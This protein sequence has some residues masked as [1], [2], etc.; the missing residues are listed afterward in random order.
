MYVH[1]LNKVEG[2]LADTVVY[3]TVT[4][5]GMSLADSDF[6]RV[7]ALTDY[8]VSRY[9]ECY[10]RVAM[11]G[12][13]AF[14]TLR[15]DGGEKK[16]VLDN[17]VT[18]RLKM[19]YAILNRYLEQ[20]KVGLRYYDDA[21]DYIDETLEL[22][23]HLGQVSDYYFS[24]KAQLGKVYRWEETE[25]L[26]DS[27]NCGMG[28]SIECD[29]FRVMSKA[30]EQGVYV[31]VLRKAR[32]T[33]GYIWIVLSGETI[34]LSTDYQVVSVCEED[35]ENGCVISVGDLLVTTLVPYLP[36][37]YPM[38]DFYYNVQVGKKSS[39]VLPSYIRWGYNI[40]HAMNICGEYYVP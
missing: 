29:T 16:I 2:Y 17:V 9:Q 13:M 36:N 27:G 15:R 26:V 33:D 37:G 25:L 30:L 19:L 3:D 32:D 28:A 34:P 23:Y 7:K 12:T 20:M 18:R 35:V 11:D 10:T 21:I 6:V 39:R 4:V 31:Y 8:M 1:R 24:S 40:Y 14:L 38:G 5:A 22:G